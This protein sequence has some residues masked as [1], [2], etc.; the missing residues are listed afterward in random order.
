MGRAG[1]VRAAGVHG[2]DREGPRDRVADAGRGQ[3]RPELPPG[4]GVRAHH[5]AL[6]DP[7]PARRRP[8]RGRGVGA[9]V[10]RR[11]HPEGGRGV[12]GVHGGVAHGGGGP[13]DRLLRGAR[14][15]GVQG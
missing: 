11:A 9:R 4:G 12:H 3:I 1:F 14:R 13:L 10:V 8:I 5:E 6:P 15:E 7:L 2:G